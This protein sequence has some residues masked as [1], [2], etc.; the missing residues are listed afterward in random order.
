MTS[1][2]IAGLAASVD[3][4]DVMR[5]AQFILDSKTLDRVLADMQRTRNHMAMLVDEYGG[6]AGLVTI[7]DVLE[8][9][10]GEIADEYDRDEVA[11]V[12]E[13]DDG[14]YRV[15]SGLPVEDPANFDI[16]IDDDGNRRR[17]GRPRA[18]RVRCPVRRYSA[19]ALNSSPR[20]GPTGRVASGSLL[21]VVTRIEPEESDDEP[22]GERQ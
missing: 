18:G 7:E 19:T 11:P 16:D 5:P 4:A 22:A 12:T 15:S 10:V 17:L 1:R 3:V 6:I 9:I 8:E 20:A 2:A 21:V 13:L 14:G